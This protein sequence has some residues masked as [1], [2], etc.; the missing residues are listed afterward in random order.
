MGLGALLFSPYEPIAPS[1]A[2]G[3]GLILGISTSTLTRIARRARA[4]K[5]LD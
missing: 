4:N 2:V 1:V 5:G 3:C